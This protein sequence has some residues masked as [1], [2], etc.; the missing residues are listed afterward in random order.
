[1][2]TLTAT[3]AAGWS[4]D[5]WLGD[6]E[7]A[8]HQT[9]PVSI[10]MANARTI[11]AVFKENYFALK[12]TKEG[13]GYTTPAFG[14]YT[15]LHDTVVVVE[16]VPEMG[17]RFDHWEGVDAGQEAENPLSIAMTADAEI[18][19]VFVPIEYAL[20]I[21]AEAGGT[22]SPTPG[23]YSYPSGALAVVAAMPEDGWQFDHWE[24]DVSGD[25]ASFLQAVTMDGSK[26]LH[27]YFVQQLYTLTLA[28]EG[29]GQI[30]PET[31]V[32]TYE[33]GTQVTAAATPAD[34][35]AF[36][37]WAFDT[38]AEYSAPE[39]TLMMDQDFTVTAVFVPVAF[40]L[41]VLTE[42]LGNT[43][44]E[45]G[46]HGYGW[47]ADI[48][49]TAT[50]EDGW[51]FDHWAGESV[52]G[53]TDNPL[54]LV[55]NADKT[56]R[57]VFAPQLWT[58]TVAVE[59]SGACS[60][61]SGTHTFQ[62]NESVS[63]AALPAEDWVFDHWT[64]LEGSDATANPVTIQMTSDM[65]VTAVFK[66]K[67]GMFSCGAGNGGA[68]SSFKGDLLLMAGVGILLTVCCHRKIWV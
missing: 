34:G 55:M 27:A 61:I 32:Y 57:A 42:G 67:S 19:A 68:K 31:G 41:T 7:E 25:P 29:S 56:V 1:V 4:F 14:S 13:F 53:S 33:Y 66:G 26:T 59:G 64:G 3:A 21:E 9:N 16:A 47:N 49:I 58:L 35:W 15:Y 50:P 54:S 45:P 12:L 22:T 40:T 11:T 23:V 60:P 20:A 30:T 65:T 10:T 52:E 44:P 62:D 48:S 5:Q 46:S 24:G 63:L 36:D 28:V 39:I 6:I 8:D 18:Q 38:S 51:R 43:M 2:V 17:W 37:H